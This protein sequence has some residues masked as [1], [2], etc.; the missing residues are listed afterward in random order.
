ME[1]QAILYTGRKQCREENS[2]GTLLF[3]K[4]FELESRYRRIVRNFSGLIEDISTMKYVASDGPDDLTDSSD[5]DLLDTV[6]AESL[7]SDSEDLDWTGRPLNIQ[8]PPFF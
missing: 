4:L 2:S 6:S 7:S 8:T 5:E 3:K 1:Q